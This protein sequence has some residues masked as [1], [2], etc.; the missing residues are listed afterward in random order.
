M[1]LT[2]AQLDGL[3]LARVDLSGA[4]LAEASLVGT[5]LAG[6][7][8]DHAVLTTANLAGANLSLASLVGA[9]LQKAVLAGANLAGADLTDADLRAATLTKAQMGEANL[10]A[11][12]LAGV[13]AQGA[14]LP[15]ATL[16]RANLEGA[17]FDSANLS[18]ARM[19]HTRLISADFR[20]AD[21]GGANLTNARARV[22]LSQD[23]AVRRRPRTAETRPEGP[24]VR[25]DGANLRGAILRGADFSEFDFTGFDLEGADLGGASL[26][27]ADFTEAIL[28]GAKLNDADLT[29]ADLVRARV[30]G[31]TVLKGAQVF[32]CTVDRSTLES[33]EGYGGLT[34]GDRM[35]MHIQDAMAALRSYYSGFWSYIHLV[36]LVLFLSP[37]LWFIVSRFAEGS[38]TGMIKGWSEAKL[39]LGMKLPE[40]KTIQMPLYE[41]VGRY[42]WTGGARWW[43]KEGSRCDP[44]TFAGFCFL[45]LYNGLRLVMLWRTKEFELHEQATGIPLSISMTGV[46]GR[47]FKVAVYGFFVNLAIVLLH[48]WHFMAT[49]ILIRVY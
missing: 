29:C 35:K 45:L 34:R 32:G 9:D 46:W 41:A 30:D 36:A 38:Y 23:P 20:N 14:M 47:L 5:N 6:A 37:Y 15:Q 12:N 33:L 22:P 31:D 18:R 11:A 1:E 10:E 13:H 7:K 17:L 43:D 48:T 8:L 26:V 28:F 24:H 19:A 44:W 39:P 40:V 16:T 42:I 49:E 4:L 21:L 27:R 2:G 3:D 25:L